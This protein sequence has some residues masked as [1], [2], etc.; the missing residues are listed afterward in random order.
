MDDMIT[1]EKWTEFNKDTEKRKQIM[2]NISKKLRLLHNN[3]RCIYG[4]N[5]N[6]IQI[7]EDN[8]EVL[9][10]DNTILITNE[11]EYKNRNIKDFS[12]YFI[13]TYLEYDTSNGLMN[14]EVLQNNFDDYSYIFEENEKNYFREVLLENKNI[15]YDQYIDKEYSQTSNSK[16][17]NKSL[18]LSTGKSYGLIGE[19]EGNANY[20]IL[21]ILTSI[22][23]LIGSLSVIYYIFM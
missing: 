22:I 11:D 20:I 8:N 18:A 6:E 23:T 16:T 5:P 4:F 10:S 21:M 3:S 17:E 19:T 1:L 7:D 9:F 13:G 15:Y 14:M 12:R 2:K